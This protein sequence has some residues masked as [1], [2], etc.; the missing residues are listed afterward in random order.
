MT[1][2]NTEVDLWLAEKGLASVDEADEEGCTPLWSA[3]YQGDIELVLW[4][5][6]VGNT[7]VDQADNVG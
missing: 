1:V 4:L 2:S 6:Q 3:A 5:I 7:S